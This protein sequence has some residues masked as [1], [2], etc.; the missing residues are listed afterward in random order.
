MSEVVGYTAGVFDLFHIGHVNLLRRA[1]ENCD[2]LIVGVTVDD[3]VL[4]KGKRPVIPFAERMEVVSA[5]RYVDLAVAQ[6]SLDKIEAW[7]N[8]QFQVMFV[9]SDWQ[10]SEQ[11]KNYEEQFQA[12]GVSI[13]YFP[14]TTGTSSTLINETLNELRGRSND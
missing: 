10:G 9:G 6:T 14:Y 8:L 3:L 4:Y 7:R 2:R 11:W 12:L 13:N 1:R 5:C